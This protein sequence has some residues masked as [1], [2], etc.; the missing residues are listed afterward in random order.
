MYRSTY[1]VAP[2]KPGRHIPAHKAQRY[3][4]NGYI[5]PKNGYD[6]VAGVRSRTSSMR[7]YSFA[8][9]ARIQ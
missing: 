1:S 9:V 3:G 8:S 5:G 2:A 7:P 4:N 6:L